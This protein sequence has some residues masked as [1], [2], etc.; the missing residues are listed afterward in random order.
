MLKPGCSGIIVPYQRRLTHDV[1]FARNRDR[2]PRTRGKVKTPQYSRL[3]CE[4]GTRCHNSDYPGQKH[5]SEDG[6]SRAQRGHCLLDGANAVRKRRADR[7]LRTHKRLVGNEMEKDAR[8]V[9]SIGLDRTTVVSPG[10]Q[11]LCRDGA[12]GLG[13]MSAIRPILIVE[14]DDTFRQ[15]LVDQIAAT[16]IFQ[17][18]EAA[19][20]G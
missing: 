10:P 17:A 7:E 18:N 14:D 16:G 15:V 9:G 2:N 13:Q 19:T 8:V 1:E 6:R 3:R 5:C 11:M 12:N 4:N 20:L